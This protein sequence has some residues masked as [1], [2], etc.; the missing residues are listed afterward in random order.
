[1]RRV[2]SSWAT[3]PVS[4]PSL[5]PGPEHSIPLC[6]MHSRRRPAA[7]VGTDPQMPGDSY[8]E[9]GCLMPRRP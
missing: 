2:P 1:M 5:S 8:R 7:V 4:E 3:I 9:I 6:P